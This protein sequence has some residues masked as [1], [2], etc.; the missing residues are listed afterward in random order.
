MITNVGAPVDGAPSS[1]TPERCRTAVGIDVAVATAVTP[2]SA[3]QFFLEASAEQRTR[4][5]RRVV[6]Q[7][8]LQRRGQH[9]IRF[10]SK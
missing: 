2:G 3:A 5:R 9:A 8:Q 6:A 10:E 4:F 1:V 7:R